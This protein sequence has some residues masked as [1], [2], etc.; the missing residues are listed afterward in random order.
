VYGQLYRIL[1]AE[2][3]K[4]PIAGPIST[5][6][7]VQVGFK[8]AQLDVGIPPDRR[9]TKL[10]MQECHKLLPEFFKAFHADLKRREEK[11][12]VPETVVEAE[13]K[14]K[15]D[16][17]IDPYELPSH[18]ADVDL[19]KGKATNA[20]DELI[21]TY[22]ALA[23]DDVTRS[24]EDRLGKQEKAIA[25]LTARFDG[26]TEQVNKA[27]A[28]A[29]DAHDMIEELIDGSFTG[30]Q[31]AKLLAL[32]GVAA[33]LK[34][35]VAEPIVPQLEKVKAAKAAKAAKPTVAIIGIY[36]SWREILQREF[37]D[38]FELTLY[39]GRE[40][41]YGSSA[42]TFMLTSFARHDRYWVAKGSAQ[43]FKHVSGGL[44]S[45]KRE[46]NALKAN[47]IE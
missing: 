11:L 5:A 37:G 6:R 28:L 35:V 18:V 3:F 46:L 21:A 43:N 2:G 40:A 29:T 10:T 25:H 34:T 42:Y 23:V 16:K 26:F 9:R 4:Q 39:H 32:I 45:L 36:D 8:N 33:E 27:Y 1:E 12:K 15:R 14:F 17:H 19:L 24:Y 47:L 22:V 7:V 44:S 30:E 20:L 41:S 13:P 31:R 38:V